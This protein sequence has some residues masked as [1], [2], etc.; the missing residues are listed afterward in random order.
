MTVDMLINRES[1]I[2]LSYKGNNVLFAK[3]LNIGF[4]PE[5]MF[6]PKSVLRICVERFI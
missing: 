6:I 5:G 2:A 4:N 3:T 1:R